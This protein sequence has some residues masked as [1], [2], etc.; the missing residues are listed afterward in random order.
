MD[1]A[2]YHHKNNRGNYNRKPEQQIPS[3]QQMAH[4][5]MAN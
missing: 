1:E 3:A 4:F 2:H 5:M